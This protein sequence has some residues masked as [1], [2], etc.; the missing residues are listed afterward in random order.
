MNFGGML[1]ARCLSSAMFQPA[2]SCA[3]RIW[4][5][6]KYETEWQLEI[7]EDTINKITGLF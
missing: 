4:C 6:S 2:R 7:E 1:L 3:L 5:Y